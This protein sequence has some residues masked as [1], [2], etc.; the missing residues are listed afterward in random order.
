MAAVICSSYYFKLYPSATSLLRDL[1]EDSFKYCNTCNLFNIAI[2]STIHSNPRLEGISELFAIRVTTHELIY[3]GYYQSRNSRTWDLGSGTLIGIWG[4]G[5]FLCLGPP[6]KGLMTSFLVGWR[7]VAFF[8]DKLAVVPMAIEVEDEVRPAE[9]GTV[10]K[11]LAAGW[12]WF[13]CCSNCMR[14]D[15]LLLVLLSSSLPISRHPFLSQVVS[16]VIFGLLSLV[17]VPATVIIVTLS[18]PPFSFSAAFLST[19]LNPKSKTKFPTP[20]RSRPP[21]P[22]SLLLPRSSKPILGKKESARAH[23]DT[24]KIPTSVPEALPS[25]KTGPKIPK[26]VAKKKKKKKP[27]VEG[28]KKEDDKGEANREKNDRTK[29]GES[30][31]E[32]RERRK[33]REI[34]GREPTN[35]R[36][37]ER[38]SGELEK[39]VGPP[40]ASLPRDETSWV[41][42]VPTARPLG[43]GG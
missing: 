21:P 30:A 11:Q 38:G 19:T 35:L 26:Q 10:K 41:Q 4:V 22:T 33:A 40:W 9:E 7:D 16:T 15:A 1:S 29:W 34:G 25:F 27:K 43:G 28:K 36:A 18:P 32:A 6:L 8:H 5:V 13:C 39:G 2:S 23:K 42:L 17:V 3:F 37:H 20:S 31:E 14:S 12:W 24:Q